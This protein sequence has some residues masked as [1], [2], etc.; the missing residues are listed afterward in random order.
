VDFSIFP[1]V[2]FFYQLY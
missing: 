2:Y 1:L